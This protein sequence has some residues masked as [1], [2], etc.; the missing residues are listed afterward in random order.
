[1]PKKSP[2]ALLQ[3]VERQPAELRRDQVWPVLHDLLEPQMLLRALPGRHQVK[4]VLAVGGLA[5][6]LACLARELHAE[7]LEDGLLLGSLVSGQSADATAANMNL[8][9]PTY[10]DA[11]IDLRQRVPHLDEPRV[12]VDLARQRGDGQQAGPPDEHERCNRLVEE[13][14]IAVR[15]LLQHDDVTSRALGGGHLHAQVEARVSRC[16]MGR[17]MNVS[18]W[19]NACEC[20]SWCSKGSWFSAELQSRASRPPDPPPYCFCSVE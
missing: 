19:W 6:V 8:G 5:L 18:G 7:R 9:A 2:E 14:R 10:M 16:S 12:E 13:T 4:H 17:E 3:R 20:V 1:M 15:R 11:S